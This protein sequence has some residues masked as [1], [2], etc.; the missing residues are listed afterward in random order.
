MGKTKNAVIRYQALDRCLRNPGR[1]YS[2]NDLLEACNE[3]IQ[4]LEPES[5]GIRKRQLYD[6]IKFMQDSRGYDAPIENSKEGRKTYY[7]YSDSS[8]TINK[9]PLNEMEAQQLKESL[10]T[11]T[12]FKGLPQFEWVEE[13]K[14]R[15]EHSFNLK[16]EERVISFEENPFLVGLELIGD[17]YNA[18][19][20]KQSL[21]IKY[22]SFKSDQSRIFEVHPYHLKQYNNRWF[23][24]G[25]NEAFG[26]LSNLALDRIKEIHQSVLPYKENSEYDFEDYFEDVIGVSVYEEEEIRKIQIKVDIE[27][28]PYLETK[29]VHGSQ[30]VKERREDCVLIQLELIPNSTLRL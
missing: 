27:L 6:D 12:R 10:A 1:K 13:I 25:L 30:K 23:L 26:T 17:L 16:S 22:H 29:P 5:T 24:F 14:L 21:T 19:V 7:R 15:L 20:N 9:Q 2:I 8:F 4:D 28:W 3:A 11:L 18:I